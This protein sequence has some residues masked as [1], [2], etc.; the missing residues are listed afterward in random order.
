MPVKQ[1]QRNI[2]LLYLIRFSRWFLLTM[3]IIVPFYTD[4]GLDLESVMQLRAIN[5][6]VIILM[7]IPSGYVGD[8][9]GRKKITGP[10]NHTRFR[11]IP[12]LYTGICIPG[13]HNCRDPSR[14]GFQL[15]IRF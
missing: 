10:G 9:L 13:I 1:F 12:G 6:L 8:L 15:Y 2:Y 14:A 7:E 3:P 11:R 4:N 5:S